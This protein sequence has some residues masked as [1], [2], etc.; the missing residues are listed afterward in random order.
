MILSLNA[1]SQIDIKQL[2]KKRLQEQ[3]W[4]CFVEI[5]TQKNKVVLIMLFD[6]FWL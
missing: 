3:V 2:S 5:T 6:E 1:L 4:S